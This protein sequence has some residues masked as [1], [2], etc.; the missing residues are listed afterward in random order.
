MKKL[1][2]SGILLG[3]SF[4]LLANPEP[5]IY[6]T[7]TEK[8]GETTTGSIR[9]GDQE[10][11]LSDIFNGRK[12]THVGIEHLSEDE[13]DELKDHQ[14]GPK[15]SIG[16]LQ[17]TFKSFFGKELKPP[18]FNVHFGA[19]KSLEVVDNKGLFK[20]T[21]HD[22]TTILSDDR[23]N[24]LT[25]EIYVM[26]P[27]GEQSE[28]D[29]DELSRI[30]F[31]KAPENAKTWGDGIYGTVTT[32]N[33][34]YPGRIMWDKDERLTDEELDGEDDS[35]SH[36]IKFAD[37]LSIEKDDNHSIV[38]LRDG[39]ELR[40]TGTNDVNRSN[41]GIWVD[42]PET[43]RVEI[44]WKE[45]K[46]LDIQPVQIDWLDFDDYVA[47]HK[48]LT[49]TVNL[50]DGETLPADQLVYDLNHQ[51]SAEL[52]YTD[53]DGH[54]HQM[55]LRLVKKM[56]VK[57]KHALELLMVDQ[58][59]KTAHGDRSVTFE[60]NGLVASHQGKYQW[61]KWQEVESISFD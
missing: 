15:A 60:N 53:I 5:I 26:T 52:L 42:N 23:A 25:D 45:F 7:I 16:S 6:G 58:T 59:T 48:P 30:D 20:A 19:L 61:V 49:A 3:A 9:W 43:G 11:F 39:R 14:S 54:H 18:Y 12:L 8:N 10:T 35:E 22:G 17:I 28:F 40:L 24:D 1:I 55:P 31:S 32:E 36:E 13:V 4:G 51:S 34:T 38:V 46:K 41:R 37:I 33:G 21:L 50:K 27:E 2:L 47:L 56:S 44:S 29:W 57:N